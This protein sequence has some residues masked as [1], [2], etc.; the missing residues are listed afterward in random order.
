MNLKDYIITIP[1]FPKKGIMFRDITSLIQQGEAFSYAVDLLAKYAK[2]KGATVIAGP[3]ARGFIFGSAVA[4]KLGLGFVPI[5]KPG[6][7]PRKEIKEEYSLEYGTNTLCIHEDAF[8]KNDKVFIID[9]LLATGGTAL[10][11]AHLIERS[12]ASVAG[13]GFVIDLIDLK[14]K[15]LL[16]DYDVFTLVEYEGE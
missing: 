11:A 7:L 1:D 10:A 16:H 5:R 8:N 15:E 6:K 2:E 13:F 9:D 4:Y 14:G 12:N 3:E